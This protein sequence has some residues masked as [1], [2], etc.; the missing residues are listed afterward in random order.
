MMVERADTFL[1]MKP[2]SG[3][4]MAKVSGGAPR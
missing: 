1:T 4:A 3:P 2:A